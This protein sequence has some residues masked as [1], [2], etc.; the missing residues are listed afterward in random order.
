M[1]T[2]LASHVQS[3]TNGYHALLCAILSIKIILCLLTSRHWWH[4]MF[5][6]K[7][8][9]NPLWN[10]TRNTPTTCLSMPFSWALVLIF[11]QSTPLIY[12]LV[13][14]LIQFFISSQSIW[15]PRYKQTTVL[16]PW[17]PSSHH[18]RI[19]PRSFKPMDPAHFL[20]MV[21]KY[22]QP[23]FGATCLPTRHL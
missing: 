7:L 14:A 13:I 12:L 3:T 10:S 2:T 15:L 20:M 5:L 23:T 4:P 19:S 16:Q 11:A 18:G 6:T 22:P 8:K 17:Q 9:G 1:Q 21:P